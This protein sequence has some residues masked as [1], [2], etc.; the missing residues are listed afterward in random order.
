MVRLRA[1]TRELHEALESLPFARALEKRSLPLRSYVEF[2]RGM[3]TVHGTLERSLSRVSHETVGHV[4]E[5]RLRKVPLLEKDLSYLEPRVEEPGEISGSRDAALGLAERI[6]LLEKEAPV[7][8]LGCLYVLEGATLGGVELRAR[9]AETFHLEGPEGLAYLTSYGSPETVEE[10]WRA[11]SVAMDEAVARRD[12]EGVL[13]GARETYRRIIG[14]TGAVYPLEGPPGEASAFRL[15]PE[16]GRHPIP[17]DEGEVQAALR[18]GRETWKRFPYYEYRYGERGKRFTDSDGAWLVT[19]V[20]HPAETVDH[21][22]VWLAGVLAARGMP[23]VTMEHHLETLADELE[24]AVPGREEDYGKL[25]RAAASLRQSRLEAIPEEVQASLVREFGERVGATEW[26]ERL[27]G[28][29]ELLVSAVA[30]ERSG[31]SGARKSLETWMADASR[32]PPEWVAAVE[33]ILRK[34]EE[35]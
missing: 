13:E 21:Q 1:E 24:R 15:N 4:W 18:A 12:E 17:R 6:R 32:F 7:S 3:L 29:A 11:F 23:R 26:G 30:D 31:V 28:A 10:S 14:M 2:L 27:P 22:V 20:D 16:A 5:E 34:A 9:V 8:L 33:D 25:R 19:L 35:S